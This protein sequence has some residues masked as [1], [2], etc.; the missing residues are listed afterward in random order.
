ME[1]VLHLFISCGLLWDYIAHVTWN[2]TM[3][4]NL[5]YLEIDQ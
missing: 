5:L 3:F 1:P 4:Y 2:R